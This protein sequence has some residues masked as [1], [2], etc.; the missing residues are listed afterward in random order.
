MD[1]AAHNSIRSNQSNG[2]PKIGGKGLI[3]IKDRENDTLSKLKG[4]FV[5]EN[6][7]KLSPK[8]I[9]S[10]PNITAFNQSHVGLKGSL[11]NE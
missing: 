7:D 6:V 8:S 4:S 11:F 9:F 3:N 2:F 1:P 10:P 5:G